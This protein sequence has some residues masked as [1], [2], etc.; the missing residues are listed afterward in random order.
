M[1][2]K[3]RKDAFL[4]G[5]QSL[6]HSIF[7]QSLRELSISPEGFFFMRDNFIRTHATHSVVGWLLSI[8]DRHADNLLISKITG[9]SIPIDFGYAFGVTA[10]LPIIELVPFRLTPQM[11]E[12][13]KPFA[14]HGPIREV[15]IR[16]LQMVKDN[17]EAFISALRVF[18]R[19][20][21]LDWVDNAAREAS[22]S[23]GS[24]GGKDDS[25]QF[26]PERK[27]EIVERKLSGDH[28]SLVAT[29]EV[30]H[31]RYRDK[32]QI[33]CMRNVLLGEAE[34]KRNCLASSGVLSTEEQVDCLLEAAT[35][36]SILRCAFVGWAPYI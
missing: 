10:H 11:Q 32:A 17:S 34:S 29:D 1:S 20:P 5:T 35:D 9:E 15:M 14:R 19:E 23:S 8:G 16:A 13:M 25:I 27:V 7:S 21:T 30:S 12:L 33:E 18:S 22:F 24:S 26:Y 2:A 3:S 31:G 36:P 6:D 4:T 28:P